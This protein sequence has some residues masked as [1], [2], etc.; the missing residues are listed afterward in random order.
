MWRSLVEGVAAPAATCCSYPGGGLADPV[1]DRALPRSMYCDTADGVPGWVFPVPSAGPCSI[2]TESRELLRWW[3]QKL[4]VMMEACN[5]H[6]RFIVTS[7]SESMCCSRN[8]SCRVEMGYSLVEWSV[9]LE[10]P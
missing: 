10:L 2:V 8:P 6:M 5:A 1:A 7:D 3:P 9:T 4:V